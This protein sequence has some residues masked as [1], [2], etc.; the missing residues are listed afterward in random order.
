MGSPG[1]QLWEWEGSDLPP[2]LLGDLADCAS[3][4]DALVSSSL[5]IY[6]WDKGSHS[7]ST[8]ALSDWYLY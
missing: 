6:P 4:D 2:R 5:H 8:V 1:L 3:N 7:G